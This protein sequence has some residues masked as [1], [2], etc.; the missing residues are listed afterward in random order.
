MVSASAGDSRRSGA[1]GAA[2]ETPV[3]LCSPQPG[4]AAPGPGLPPPPPPPAV[5]ASLTHTPLPLDKLPFKGVCLIL[6]LPAVRSRSSCRPG[7]WAGGRKRPVAVSY[8]LFLTHV[9]NFHKS[10]CNTKR[11]EGGG[12][13]IQFTPAKPLARWAGRGEK[14]AEKGEGDGW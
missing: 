10:F 12:R 8:E 4:A 7:R 2:T 11:E 3:L 6:Y 13:Q 5:L 9:Y 1:L 14:T